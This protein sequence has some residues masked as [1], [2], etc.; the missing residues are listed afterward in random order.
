MRI[1]LA[2]CTNTLLAELAMEEC[3]Q[4]HIAETYALAIASSED[5]DWKTVNKAIADRWSRSGL[6]RVKKM[7]WKKIDSWKG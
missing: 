2:D 6:E 1:E 3:K 5:V 4:R 7:A